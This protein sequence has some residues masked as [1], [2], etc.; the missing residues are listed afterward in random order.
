MSAHIPSKSLKQAYSFITEQFPYYKEE[1]AN[2]NKRH[3]EIPDK[4]PNW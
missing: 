2:R 4:N 1:A 3:L